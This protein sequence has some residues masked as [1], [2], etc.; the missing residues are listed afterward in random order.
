[1]R[2]QHWP[3]H[4]MNMARLLN[5]CWK[6]DWL[7]GDVYLGAHISDFFALDL[8]VQRSKWINVLT[9]LVVN[10]PPQEQAWFTNLWGRNLYFIRKLEWFGFER[11]R[12]KAWGSPSV[13]IW[14]LWKGARRSC[15]PGS[16]PPGVQG[17]R[18]PQRIESSLEAGAAPYSFLC[19]WCQ[20]SAWYTAGAQ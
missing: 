18:A 2:V 6:S 1:M 19:S 13:D 10:L 14:V 8:R 5:K 9:L 4:I 15:F 7:P 17:H 11:S 12:W 20:Q 3:H 16:P